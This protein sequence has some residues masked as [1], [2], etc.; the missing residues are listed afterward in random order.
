MIIKP[1]ETDRHFCSVV[2]K[3][4]GEDPIGT[5]ELCEHWLIIELAQ[6]WS[7]KFLHENPN[8]QQIQARV[9][10]RK[11]THGVK[12]RLMAIAPDREYSHPHTTRVLYYRR[13]SR[14][15]AQFEKQEFILP[16]AEVVSLATALLEQ[17]DRLPDFEPY[18]QQ[19]SHIREL[20]VCTHGNVDAACAR[21]GYPI[22]EK[23]RKAYA[24]ASDGQL[25]VWR[26]SHFGGHRFAPTLIDFPEGRY[27]GHL[28]P[29]VLDLLVHRNGSVTEL[30]S[31][32][33]GWSGLSQFE[34]IAEREIWMQEGWD[35][36]NYHRAG[37]VLA[38]DES[39]EGWDADWADVRIDFA[40]PDG[41]RSGAYE[42]RIEV[43]RQVITMGKS[44][45]EQSLK[46]IKQYRVSRLVKVT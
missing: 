30:R 31:F 20:L 1:I 37:Q 39:N 14:L 45:D 33:R 34:Q 10:E 26:C 29:K 17:P 7:E 11:A 46:G 6:P 8:I 16:D 15:F 43:S 13:P 3:A 4:S 35:W 25:R 27:W 24:A 9:Q 12:I 38:I 28:E 5:A 21:F 2:S 41:S 40:S 36:L 18:Q 32:C 23:L 44:G 19:T 22:Y 42:A